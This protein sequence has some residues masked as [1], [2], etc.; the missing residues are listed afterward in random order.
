MIDKENKEAK[1]YSVSF[2][3][4]YFGQEEVRIGSAEL[5][6]Q[7][8]IWWDK[9]C[10][11]RGFNPRNNAFEYFGYYIDELSKNALEYCGGGEVEVIFL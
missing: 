6:H 2:T 1:S 4:Y 5:A 7:L 9:I 11:E 8:N 10:L 3:N